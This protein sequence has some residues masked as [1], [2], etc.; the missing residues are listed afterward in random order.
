MDRKGLI[1]YLID[2]CEYTQEQ[3]D[4]M[5]ARDMVD[6]WLTYTGIVGFT[7]DIL[8]VVKAT[9]MTIKFHQHLQPTWIL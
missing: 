5:S 2:E 8:E 6:A 4:E 9:Y 3:V 7:D 1:E